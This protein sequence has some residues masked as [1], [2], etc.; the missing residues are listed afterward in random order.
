MSSNSEKYRQASH[1][2]CKT[3]TAWRNL[4]FTITYYSY[5]VVME[6]FELLLI[7]LIPVR[8]AAVLFS[9]NVSVRKTVKYIGE[10][11]F[12]GLDFC[13]LSLVLTLV[14][15]L[16]HSPRH[17]HVIFLYWKWYIGRSS[18]INFFFWLVISYLGVNVFGVFLS[19]I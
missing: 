12:G 6:N 15:I 16:D 10:S 18:L 3:L 4:N 1:A 14:W 8:R 2:L 5:T 11:F 9:F 19:N 17:V 13:H 7:F